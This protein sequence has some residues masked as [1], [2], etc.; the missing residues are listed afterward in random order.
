MRLLPYRTADDR[1]DGAVLT[2]IDITA[3][4]KAEEQARIGE[5]RPRLVA[6]S[7]DDYAIIVQ[8]PVGCIS[9]GSHQDGCWS[10]SNAD[11]EVGVPV[12][13]RGARRCA[14]PGRQSTHGLHPFPGCG[15][16]QLFCLLSLVF[17]SAPD[18]LSTASAFVVRW[19][20]HPL[21]RP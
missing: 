8:D 9:N 7:T 2:L 15:N 6:Q 20:E 16:H 1:I 12:P 11:R 4:H 5:Q 13:A 18:F 10:M 3:R 19:R 14:V 21:T 17:L